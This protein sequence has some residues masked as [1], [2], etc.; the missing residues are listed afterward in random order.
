ME[1]LAHASGLLR[2]ASDPE[3]ATAMAAYMKSSMPFYGVTSPERRKIMKE[4]VVA[5]PV[6]TNDDYRSDVA[7]L[8]S[9]SHREEKYLAIRWARRHRQFIAVENID[10]YQRMIIE[11]A[12]WDF[13]DEIAANL[14]GE[15]VRTEPVAMQSMLEVWLDGADVWLRR[16]VIIS[17][18]KS[19]DVTNTDLLFEAC[20]RNLA[21]PEFFI[22]KAIGWALREHSKT[23]KHSV[24][25]FVE[26]HRDSM[27]GLSL[28]E[29]SKYL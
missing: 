4:L 21:D 1:I 10:L 22:R 20:R 19:K 11:G 3:T 7:S 17:Q 26:K 13:V 9:G 14:V 24:L 8:W 25:E 5:H 12:W 15:L 6:E 2:T 29:A 16:S 27:S 18:L 28:R 23:D